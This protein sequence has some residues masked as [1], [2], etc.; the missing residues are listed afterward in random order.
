MR[1]AAVIALTVLVAAVVPPLLVATTLRIVANDWVVHFE[2]GRGGVPPDRYGLTARERTELALVGL[3][4]IQPWHEEGTALLEA[5]RLPGGEPAFTRRE[6]VHM[7]D[8]RRLVGAAFTFQLAALAG[9]AALAA[10]LSRTRL[11]AVAPRGLQLGGAATLGVAALL[12]A[13]MLVAWERFFADFHRLF[14]SGES[15]RFP[16]SD[17]LI[18]LYPDAFWTGVAALLA[19][20]TVALALLTLAAGTLWLRALRRRA[21][22]DK[23]PAGAA[24][25]RVPP[26]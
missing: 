15:W 8:V 13:A 7:A 3:R 5:A 16:S 12:G 10:A 14:F 22:R 4:S 6:I 17:T 20:G 18:R 9:L 24:L 23:E 1:R 21:E 25:N 26:P 11:R 19:G 2:Y